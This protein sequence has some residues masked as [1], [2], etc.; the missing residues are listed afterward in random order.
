M[1]ID[2]EKFLAG[3]FQLR[4]RGRLRKREQAAGRI[5]AAQ[6]QPSDFQP[7][8]RIAL[9]LDA[10]PDRQE[11]ALRAKY[12]DGLSVAQIAAQ[13]NETPKAIES[14]LSRAREA[15]RETYEKMD[16]G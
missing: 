5:N 11:A 12:L 8:D 9:T 16:E 15:F 7:D 3:R 2:S 6:S 1:R 13:W 10:L 4:Q 14:L